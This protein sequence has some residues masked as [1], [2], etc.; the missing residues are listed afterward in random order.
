LSHEGPWI[1]AT[2]SG[3]EP[4]TPVHTNGVAAK[5]HV[6]G[7]T[8]GGPIVDDEG[9]LLGIVSWTSEDTFEGMMPRPHRAV[10]VWVWT[11]IQRAQRESAVRKA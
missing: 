9:E 3:G 2:I 1:D 7:G 10:P 11:A 8:S 5:S 6:K 4:S